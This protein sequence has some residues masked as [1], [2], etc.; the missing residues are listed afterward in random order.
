M[1]SIFNWKASLRCDPD[2]EPSPIERGSVL[3]LWRL[4]RVCPQ[5]ERVEIQNTS[6]NS[7]AV[8]VPEYPQILVTKEVTVTY[9]EEA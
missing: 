1:S 3:L 9:E 7:A 5:N 6:I 4:W 8:R 2:V